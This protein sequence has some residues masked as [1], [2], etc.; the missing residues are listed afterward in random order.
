M[1]GLQDDLPVKED[2][3]ALFTAVGI[4]LPGQTPPLPAQLIAQYFERRRN[5]GP[6]LLALE[7]GELDFAEGEQ[8]GLPIT[9]G[10]SRCEARC[11]SWLDYG[12]FDTFRDIESARPAA[13]ALEARGVNRIGE[14][15]RLSEGRLAR[16][17]HMNP[18]ALAAMV[19]RL[20]RAGFQLGRPIDVAAPAQDDRREPKF[21]LANATL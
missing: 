8:L 2:D 3:D 4:V 10:H 20:G 14:L 18:T 9:A 12:V 11:P 6:V 17:R 5:R 1:A 19:E 15:L 13:L 7:P 16:S 21:R